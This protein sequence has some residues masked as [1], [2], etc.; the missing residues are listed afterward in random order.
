MDFYD[1]AANPISREEWVDLFES[2]PDPRRVASTEVGK[3]WVS[4][5]WLGIDHRFGGGGPPLI[6]ESMVFHDGEERDMRRY[7]NEDAALAGHD[8]L[9]A[10]VRAGEY[11]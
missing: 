10:A 7:T 9:V 3:F 5:V 11:A 2:W 6:F 8:Q 4:T 1:R